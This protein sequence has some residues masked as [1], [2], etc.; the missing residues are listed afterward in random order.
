MNW[1]HFRNSK[2]LTFLVG[3]LREAGLPEW[4]FNFSA[5]DHDRLN[6]AAIARLIPD[7]TLQGRVEPGLPAMMQVGRDGTAAFRTSKQFFTEK[8]FVDGDDLCEQSESLFGRAD[9][10]P[11]YKRDRGADELSFAYVNSGKVFY[12]SPVK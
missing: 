12:F 1:R 2:D 3:A 8:V 11:V 4:P 5:D 7:H 6:G 10:G 9:C